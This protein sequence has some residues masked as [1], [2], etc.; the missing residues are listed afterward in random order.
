MDRGKRKPKVVDLAAA[1]YDDPE[2]AAKKIVRTAH[3]KG[4]EDNLTAMVPCKPVA[5]TRL[6][7]A[8]GVWNE[9]IFS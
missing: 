9:G 2:E 1:H 8:R 4:S 6:L 7:T 3:Q 5:N